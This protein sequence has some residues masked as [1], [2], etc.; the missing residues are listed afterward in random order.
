M[1]N[2]IEHKDVVWIDRRKEEV[3][4]LEE[5]PLVSGKTSQGIVD[6]LMEE[7]IEKVFHWSAPNSW[8]K[9][10]P[11]QQ[12]SHTL[13]QLFQSQVLNSFDIELT[14]EIL[15]NFLEQG[16]ESTKEDGDKLYALFEELKRLNKILEEIR[17]KGLSCLKP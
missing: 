7:A 9:F 6:P 12:Y 10:F 11:F 17:L 5:P 1:T 16:K 14:K 2:I 3:G 8:A 13:C 4:Y 15:D